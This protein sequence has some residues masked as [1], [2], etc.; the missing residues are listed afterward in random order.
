[1]MKKGFSSWEIGTILTPACFWNSTWV[2]STSRPKL[3]AGPD[4]VWYPP[5][6]G[7]EPLPDTI[8]MNGLNTFNCSVPPGLDPQSNYT[9]QSCTGGK[10]YNLPVQSGK[11][12]RLRLI[13]PGSYAGLYFTIDSHNLTIIEADGTDITPIEVPGLYVNIGQR[14]SVIFKANETAGNYLM[15]FNLS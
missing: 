14:Y 8:L 11:S 10:L 9:K 3:K 2:Y 6:P 7:T 1:M 13:N 12:Y 15:R 4:P 5:G